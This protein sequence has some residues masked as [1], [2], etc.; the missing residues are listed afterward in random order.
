M[1]SRIA[2]TAITAPRSRHTKARVASVRQVDRRAFDGTRTGSRAGAPTPPWGAR[3]GDPLGDDL[4]DEAGPPEGAFTL[5][6][7]GEA[8]RT[9]ASG[10]TS[11]PSRA[12]CIAAAKSAALEKRSSGFLDNARSMTFVRS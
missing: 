1:V 7:S 4:D 8:P 12:A 5:W 11:A 6:A 3:A 2:T 10:S 9:A